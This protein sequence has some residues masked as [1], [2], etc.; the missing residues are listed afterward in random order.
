[1]T[2][3]KTKNEKAKQTIQIVTLDEKHQNMVNHFNKRKNALPKKK[4]RLIFL[5]KELANLENDQTTYTM[6]NIQKRS[7]TR[8]EIKSLREEIYDIENC[9][10]EIEYYSM[11][12]DILM[13]YYE[14]TEQDDH[15]LYEN[16][17]ELSAVKVAK[18][19][20]NINKLELLNQVNKDK[21][22]VK[23]E[24]KR[25]KKRQF[26]CNRTNILTF[27]SVLQPDAEK[28]NNECSKKGN[29]N[30]VNKAELLDQFM[31]LTDKNYICEKNKV[32][33]R[34]RICD[35][36][37]IEKTL[38][39]SE[40]MIVCTGCGRAE[41]VIID[42]EKPNY[43]ETCTETKPGYPYK[44]INHYNEWLSQFQAKES[45]E[46]PKE[47]YD[48]ILVEL[49]KMKFYDLKKLTIP[50]TKK[51]LKSLG[52]TNYYEHT[53][54]IISKLSG[55]QPP[56]INR[57]T[58]EK[59][60]FMFKQ[61]QVPFEKHKPITRTNFLSYSYVLHKQCELLE[62]DEFLKCFP[63]LKSREKL[64]QQDCIWKKIC[65]ELE[66]EYFPSI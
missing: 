53:T 31:M 66:W 41:F 17:P 30:F 18:K 58:E 38:I 14:I 36:C 34:V 33:N 12:D 29:S 65:K 27:I 57:D 47:V 10:S 15:L 52:Y 64:K 23:K 13:D 20:H 32:N 16:N 35:K 3:F 63:L 4:E 46:I 22:K 24:S 43:K 48:K 51:I 49:Q 39:N 59:L 5:E 6:K 62:L 28:E 37:N 45:T 7:Q 60:R 61:I 2:T 8:S 21:R 19:E 54:H 40:G 26:S 42:A 9:V 25:R 44:R 1:M 55:K 50:G 11:V 56:T